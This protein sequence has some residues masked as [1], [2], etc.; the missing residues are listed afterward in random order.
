[1]ALLKNKRL[2]AFTLIEAVT[3]MI[4]IMACFSISTM[5]YLNIIKSD[6]RVYRSEAF[7]IV[8]Q[9]K[10]ETL[11]NRQFF[12]QDQEVDGIIFSRTFENYQNEQKLKLMRI[13]ARDQK[14]RVL[15]SYKQV[16]VIK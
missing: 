4:I 13:E 9:W 7:L 15:Y 1:M 3:S 14:K 12:D 2:S 11:K 6:N 10:E 5:I 16:V 8:N